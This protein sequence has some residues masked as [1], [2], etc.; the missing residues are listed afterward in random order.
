MRISFSSN[1]LHLLISIGFKS[2]KLS[3]T[4]S[5][6]SKNSSPPGV[7][8]LLSLAP[9]LSTEISRSTGTVYEVLMF[10]FG[11]RYS[12]IIII[13]SSDVDVKEAKVIIFLKFTLNYSS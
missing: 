13:G 4:L 9:L 3:Y 1:M 11:L 8:S 2:S 5:G 7:I 10:S 12:F 6:I